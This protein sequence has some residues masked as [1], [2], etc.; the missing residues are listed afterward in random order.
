[1]TES[2]LSTFDPNVDALLDLLCPQV[3]DEMLREIAGADY[4]NDVELHLAPLKLFRD[5]R[6]IPELTWHPAEVLELIRWSEPDDPEW[7]PGGRGRQGHLL[8]AF[9]CAT[10]LR[11]YPAPPNEK[12]WHS[13]NETAVQLVISLQVLDGEL[14]PAGIR[15][16]AWCLEHLA[17]L[18]DEGTEA[19]FLG[20]ALLA[21][22]ARHEGVS[23]E[24]VVGL[25]RWID[26]TV[27]ALLPDKQWAAT[28]RK[29]WLLSMN[30]HD[31]RNTRW[32]EVGR[33]LYGWAEAQP[34]SDRATWVA[35]IGRALSED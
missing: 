12:V 22:A 26:D 17:A 28:R 29:N 20:I 27:S 32:I 21:L 11:A 8:R 7:K 23:D 19:V 34:S 25:C 18:D 9:S 30:H 24:A 35:L 16:F 31:L 2:W 6:V 4:G 5:A 15:F 10:L 1:V 14:I 13:F 3:D 33:R